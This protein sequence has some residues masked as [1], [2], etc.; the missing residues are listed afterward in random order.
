MSGKKILILYVEAENKAAP[1][2][3]LA[4]LADSLIGL[5]AQVTLRE[6]NQRYDEILDA[7]ALADSVIFW[8]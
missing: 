5:G 2:A 8:H 7:V 6:C 1:G 3:R 4:D